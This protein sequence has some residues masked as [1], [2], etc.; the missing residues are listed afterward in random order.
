MT[1]T[2]ADSKGDRVITTTSISSVLAYHSYKIGGILCKEYRRGSEENGFF[3]HA[4]EVAH[5]ERFPNI[6]CV[7]F[8]EKG[9]LVVKLRKNSVE[10]LG[11]GY[12]EKRSENGIEIVH[13]SGKV[14]FEYQVKKYQNVAVTEICAEC[15]DH[16]GEK[17]IL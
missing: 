1:V 8:D 5:P 12:S 3:F 15:F 14:V 7:L 2:N 16:C 11:D 6:S 17:I 4:K 13:E 10:E 9:K